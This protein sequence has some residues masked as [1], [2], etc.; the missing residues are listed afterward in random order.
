MLVS[1]FAPFGE[2]SPGISLAALVTWM[3]F[4]GAPYVCGRGVARMINDKCSN[5]RNDG[6]HRRRSKLGGDSGK[7]G[8]DMK[9]RPRDEGI[10]QS[11]NG[12]GWTSKHGMVV[13]LLD[14]MLFQDVGILQGV[15]S[16]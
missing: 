7:T 4:D 11:M 16:I 1:I 15:G 12:K 3:N 5:M 14:S 2:R 13:V 10:D 9:V 6:R 8:L